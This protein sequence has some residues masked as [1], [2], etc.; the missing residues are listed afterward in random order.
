M[1]IDLDR[2]IQELERD[3]GV[4]N[5]PYFDSMGNV[6]I[7]VGHLLIGVKSIDKSLVW[8][9]K[10]VRDTLIADIQDAYNLIYDYDWFKQLDTDNRRRALVN[11][12][13]NLG[14]HL[15][16]FNTFLVY[17]KHKQWSLAAQDLATTL[18]HKQLP[19]RSSRIMQMIKSG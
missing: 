15:L 16:Q 18:W 9:D 19:E 5:A 4:R 2:M 17:L 3:E 13:F 1:N 8:T 11:M 14:Y 12:S 10:Q 7:G 6:T